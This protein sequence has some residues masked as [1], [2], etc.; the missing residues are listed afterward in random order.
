MR[1][2]LG[3]SLIPKLFPM[4]KTALSV[5]TYLTLLLLVFYGGA[6]WSIVDITDER[7]ETVTAFV[8]AAGVD[9]T[10]ETAKALALFG[11]KFKA[12][13]QRIGPLFGEGH[14]K[15]DENRKMAICCLVV[16][17]LQWHLLNQSFDPVSRTYN[18]KIRSVLSVADF[19]KAEIRNELLDEEEVH[20]SLKEEMEPMVSPAVTPALDLSRAYRYISHGHWRMAIIYMDRLETKYPYWGELKL[21]KAIAY[22]EMNEQNRAISAL[23]SACHLGVQEACLKINALDPSVC[24]EDAPNESRPPGF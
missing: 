7:V 4:S 14:S 22:L 10:P 16:D 3:C 8:Y 1:F 11:A 21:A 18:V 19:V 17:G 2:A 20:F 13:A 15:A 12:V 23:A 5:S 9:E 6:A 24:S